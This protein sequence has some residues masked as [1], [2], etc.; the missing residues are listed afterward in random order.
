MAEPLKVLIFPNSL[1][2]WRL[3]ISLEELGLQYNIENVDL[4]NWEH[5]QPD[6]LRCSPLGSVPVLV[7]PEGEPLLGEQMF[8][9]VQNLSPRSSSVRLFS[10][11]E[12]DSSVVRFLHKLDDLKVGVLTYGL[13]FHINQTSLLRSPYCNEEFFEKSSNYILSRSDKLQD[14]AEL[15]R[16]ESPDISLGL[17]NLA[18]D[19]QENLPDYLEA[20]GYTTVLKAYHKVLDFFE[21]ELGREDRHGRWLGGASVSIADITL[22]LH[23]HRLWQLGMEKEFYQ[24]GVRPHLAVFYETIRAR[25]AF[26]KV[27]QWRDRTEERQI[28][29]EEDKVAANAKWGLGAAA[30]IGG[31]FL[32]KKFLKK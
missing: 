26:E 32:V 15:M 4:F 29:S 16:S 3:L 5:L 14:A 18:E 21:D 22:G 28:L 23:L 1:S 24:D 17:K 12:L 11:E 10:D 19:H 30:V 25:Q 31:L 9:A 20:E 13:A 8:R 27:T 2:S 6:H 7:T